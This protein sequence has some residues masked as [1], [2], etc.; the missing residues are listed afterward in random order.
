MTIAIVVSSALAVAGLATVFPA[1]RAACMSTVAAPI[2]VA[3]Q[4]KRRVR[5]I[6][7][8]SRFP[9]PLLLAIRIV[10]RRP[11]RAL[12][13]ISSIAI[14]VSGIVALLFAHATIAADRLGGKASGSA[15]FNQFDVGVVSKTA[16]EDQVLLIVSIALVAL[17]AVNVLFITRATVQDTQH[18]RRWPGRLA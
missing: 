14:T 17:A 3:R 13:S 11:R 1:L 18:A 8:S 7:N 9:V 15:D 5:L 16:R 10:A 4:P 2:D 6:R 12:P